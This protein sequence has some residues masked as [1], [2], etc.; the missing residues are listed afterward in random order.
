MLER[1]DIHAQAGAKTAVVQS[2]EVEVRD[3]LLDIELAKGVQNPKLSA[4][5]IFEAGGAALAPQPAPA[6]EISGGAFTLWDATRDAP[7]SAMGER[8]V[9]HEAVLHGRD[10]SVTVDPKD[11][12]ASVRMTLDGRAPQT[13]NATPYALFGDRRGDLH[14]GSWELPRGGVPSKVTAEYFAATGAKGADLGRDVVSVEAGAG[15]MVG[16]KGVADV[17]VLDERAMG[18]VHI[19]NFEGHDRVSLV[20]GTSAAKLAQ[21]L[22]AKDGD[23]VIDLGA[24]HALTIADQADVGLSDLIL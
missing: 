7:I 14:G 10:P 21:S 6:K 24:G 18:A 22:R 13:E 16:A 12:V 2:F 9:V 23:A 5:A 19:E 8:T 17:F 20:G 1:F 11:G 4:L 3:G 15:R